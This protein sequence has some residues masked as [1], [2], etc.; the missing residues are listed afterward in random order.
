MSKNT[1]NFKEMRNYRFCIYP[2]KEQ[3]HKLTNWL[4]TCRIIYNSAVA[5]LKNRYEHTGKGLP[6]TEQQVILKIDKS[7][8]PRVKEVH[9]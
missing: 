2:N 4:A 8:H 5:D 3:E 7:K 9:S 6:R 1:Y